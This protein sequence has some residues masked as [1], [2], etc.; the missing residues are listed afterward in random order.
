MG[1]VY[2]ATDLLTGQHVA[3]KRVRVVPEPVL[4]GLDTEGINL[5]LA[6]AHEFQL[7]A[8]LRHPHIIHV[9]DYGF[10]DDRQPYFTM[11]LLENAQ[12]LLE[13]GA[14]QPLHV[15]VDLLTQTLQALAYLHRRGVLHRDLKP[16]N[17]LVT[18]GSNGARQSVKVM[19]FGLS[20]LRWQQPEDEAAGTPSYMAPEVLRGFPASEA[21]DLYAIGVMA[22]EL[23]VGRYPYE[24]SGTGSIV[25]AILSAQPGFP[26]TLDR[27]IAGVL[28]RQMTKQ[29]DQR[30]QS[31]EDVIAA[32][33]Q[34]SGRPTVTETAATRESFLQAAAFV[35]RDDEMALLRGN[36]D[37]AIA[38]HGSTWLVGGESGVG[39]SRLLSE[40]RTLAM[41]KGALVLRGQAI[42][43][44]GSPYEMWRQPIQWLA[45][46]SDLNART[47]S[48]LKPVVPNI[49]QF[50][51]AEISEPAA[52]DPRS[53]Q[54][55]LFTTVSDLLRQRMMPTLIILEDLHWA[56]DE[57]LALLAWLNRISPQMPLMIVGSF[58]DDE[59]IDLP[60]RLPDMSVLRLNRLT[61]DAI[62]QLSEHMLG[63]AGAAPDVV[64][65]LEKETEGNVFFLVEVV[66]SLAEEAGQL[67]RIADITLPSHIMAGGVRR[68]VA[69]RVARVP[70]LYQPL[71]RLAAVF[72]RVLDLELLRAAE[73]VV[74][75]DEWLSVVSSAAVLD[76]ADG[77]WQF[78][79]DKLREY[80]LDALGESERRELHRRAALAIEHVYAGRT[81]YTAALVYHWHAAG[82][83]WR[84]GH[85][86]ALAGQQSLESGAYHKAI[87]FLERAF[88]LESQPTARQRQDAGKLRLLLGETLYGLGDY[89]RAR[90][91]LREGVVL[92]ERGNDAAGVAH[93]LML[94]GNIALARGAYTDASELLQRS[95]EV[96]QRNDDRL[97][98]GRAYRSLGLVASTIGET[99][100]ARRLF[101]TSLDLLTGVGNALGMA[102][103]LSNLA[104]IAH[105]ERDYAEARRLYTAALDQFK[106]VDFAWG[107]AYTLT[108]LGE[109]VEALGEYAEARTLHE[110]ALEICRDIGHRWGMGL[111]L[112]HIASACLKLGQ[113]HDCHVAILQGLTIAV[114]IGTT[115]LTLLVLSHYGGLLLRAASLDEAVELLTLVM[116]HPQVEKETSLLAQAS[117]DEA[118]ALLPAEDFEAAQARGAALA[119]GDAV[120]LVLATRH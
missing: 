101:E 98:M 117:L 83:S 95:L 50:T 53:A 118:R 39:K 26:S 110:R 14:G 57:S 49:A 77:Q 45:L 116:Q 73:P 48:V 100:E 56:D 33:A 94:L 1:V 85:Y 88:A 17:I 119:L 102:G 5:R 11:E 2:R 74:A 108:S 10:D 24:G 65:F 37:A 36:L 40:L 92:F 115:P 58:R 15:Q 82:D 27:R 71:L 22:Y 34:A 18:P 86:A 35:G 43:D 32:L 90:D 78:S 54:T 89:D 30:Y 62:G 72:G 79:H 38:G 76:V 61:H 105:T 103:A 4:P 44:G 21:S 111:C 87:E 23:L 55:R 99:A 60:A 91:V 107:I 93:A 20:V 114:E 113:L 80:L 29:P 7:L 12:T 120:A 106:A 47:A 84:E 64:D 51:E 6:L 52:I 68:I 25:Q 81:D 75:W 104:G 70:T 63:A 42:G 96:A 46:L 9:L 31:A 16:A 97:E 67:D 109:T 8:S 59:A 41:V 19:D 3:L 69:R 66:R 13:A 112:A 28:A